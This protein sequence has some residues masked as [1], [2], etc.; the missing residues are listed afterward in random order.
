M[1]DRQISNNIIFDLEQVIYNEGQGIVI[2]D[3]AD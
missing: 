1:I 2:R 3:F